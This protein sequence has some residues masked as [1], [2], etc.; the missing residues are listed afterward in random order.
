MGFYVEIHTAYNKWLR[1][2]KPKAKTFWGLK[3]RELSWSE[4][5]IL[6]TVVEGANKKQG[7]K[8]PSVDNGHTHVKVAIRK[9]SC[10]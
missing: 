10:Y 3:K 1:Y 7:A 2:Q 9:A 8:R 4:C 6:P 5:G